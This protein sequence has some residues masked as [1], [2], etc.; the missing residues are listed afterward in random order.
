[1]A[2]HTDFKEQSE[3]KKINNG[4]KKRNGMARKEIVK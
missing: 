1:M 2:Y 4:R 3:K